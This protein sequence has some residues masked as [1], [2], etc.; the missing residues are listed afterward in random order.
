MER[1]PGD[2]EVRALRGTLVRSD[3]TARDWLAAAFLP[4]DAGL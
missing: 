1:V 3:R 2:P 4:P